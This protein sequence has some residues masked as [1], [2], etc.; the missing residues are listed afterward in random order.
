M[1]KFLREYG[2]AQTLN[3]S[4]YE[5]DGID[6]RKDAVY[7]SGDVKISKNEATE[8][9]TTNSFTDG[10]QGYSIVLTA[11]EMSFARLV[12]YIVDQ[13]GTKVWLDDYLVVETYGHANAQHALNLNNAISAT[14]GIVESNLKEIDDDSVV[15]NLATLTLKQLHVENEDDDAVVFTS[16]DTDGVGLNIT[17]GGTGQGML[18]TAGLTG[19]GAQIR[20][21]VNDGTGMIIEALAGNA[22]ALDLWPC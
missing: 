12:L 3:F 17:G 20:G 22:S 2:V 19:V 5:V 13:T 11:A 9:N 7:A 4:L 8:V 6:F 1:Q 10:G 21:G 18:I 16:T 14:A 15:G